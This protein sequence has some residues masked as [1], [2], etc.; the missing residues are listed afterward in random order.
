MGLLGAMNRPPSLV[1]WRRESE[2]VG[3]TPQ[4]TIAYLAWCA[5]YA[6]DPAPSAPVTGGWVG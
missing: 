1:S 5:D 2:I 6:D 4:L 3:H